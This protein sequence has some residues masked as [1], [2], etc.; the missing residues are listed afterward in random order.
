M[1]RILAD[2]GRAVPPHNAPLYIGMLVMQLHLPGASPPVCA[3]DVAAAVVRSAAYVRDRYA[4]SLR[5]T[6]RAPVPGVPRLVPFVCLIGQP[7]KSPRTC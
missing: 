4:M 5:P 3:P 7:S 2:T 6:P 1:A